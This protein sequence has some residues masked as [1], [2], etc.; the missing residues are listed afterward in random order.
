[1]GCTMAK[2]FGTST[3]D[4]VDGDCRTV[5]NTSQ[6]FDARKV[7]EALLPAKLC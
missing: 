2:S 6:T 5:E 7:A 1:M 3:F 4:Y